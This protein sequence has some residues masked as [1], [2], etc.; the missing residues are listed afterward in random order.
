MR[1]VWKNWQHPWSSHI[2]LNGMGNKKENMYEFF[3]KV[4][5]LNQKS[6]SLKAINNGCYENEKLLSLKAK[7]KNY[8]AFDNTTYTAKKTT[9]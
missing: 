4:D 3:I 7:L 8:Y 5:K 1:L 6:I 2:W 9:T